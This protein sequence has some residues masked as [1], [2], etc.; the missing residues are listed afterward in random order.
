MSGLIDRAEPTDKAAINYLKNEKGFTDINISAWYARILFEMGYISDKHNFVCPT[1]D[2]N[3]PITCHAIEKKSKNSPSPSFRN[4]SR[5]ENL[6][7]STCNKDPLSLEKE[8]S[9]TSESSNKYENINNGDYVSKFKNKMFTNAPQP[10]KQQKSTNG[11]ESQNSS[12][13]ASGQNNSS[14]EQMKKRK[15]NSNLR[16]LQQYVDLYRENKEEIIFSE[17]SQ[18]YIPI[19]FMFKVIYNNKLSKDISPNDYSNIYYG[20]VK[21]KETQY[22]GKL[23]L[24]FLYFK[25]I[26]D[27]KYHP[28]FRVDSSYLESKYNHIYKAYMN[29][30]KEFEVYTT[31]PFILQKSN[32]NGQLYL[33]FCSFEENEE[34]KCGSEEF[35]NNFI[36]R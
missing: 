25:I 17:E 16:T 29:G 3:A 1:A 28:S 9:G 23:K 15:N 8:F 22:E 34:L 12:T 26:D 19:K 4:H 13:H 35:N 21:I 14:D 5:S 10:K 7:I 30:K 20:R 31:F 24:E 2:C 33:N 6:H 11:K 36:I 32:T 18:R 27:V